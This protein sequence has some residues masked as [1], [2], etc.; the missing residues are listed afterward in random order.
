MEGDLMVGA[1]CNG[2]YPKETV[3]M[4][5]EWVFR[6][7]QGILVEIHIKDHNDQIETQNYFV[8]FSSFDMW[9]KRA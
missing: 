9:L 5:K 8:Y 4:T 2:V 7:S 3:G 1:Y 6:Q